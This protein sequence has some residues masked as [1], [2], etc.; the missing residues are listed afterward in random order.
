MMEESGSPS[1]L[2]T[3]E[4]GD[5]AET[6]SEPA[7]PATATDKGAVSKDTDTA[8]ADPTTLAAP[9]VELKEESAADDNAENATEDSAATPS[10]TQADAGSSLSSSQP[11]SAAEALAAAIL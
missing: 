3:V 11:R 10:T 8:I 6:E 5:W 4:H 9:G 2:T 1:P 7:A